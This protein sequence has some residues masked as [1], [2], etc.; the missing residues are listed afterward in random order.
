M[1]DLKDNLHN[2]FVVDAESQSKTF[3]L[4]QAAQELGL[5]VNLSSAVTY[6]NLN[7]WGDHIS[8][9]LS[10]ADSNEMANMARVLLPKVGTFRKQ[11]EERTGHIGVVGEYKGVQIM[12]DVPA[13][14]TCHVEVVEEE[15]EVPEQVIEAHTVTKRRYVLTGDCDPLLQ[16]SVTE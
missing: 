12:L 5:L 7:R 16:P 1:Y 14:S 4:Y 6:T 9:S 8:I 2:L 13:P 10:F 15:V 11:F 3:R